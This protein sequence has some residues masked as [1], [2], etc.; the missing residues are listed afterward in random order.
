MALV[1][2]LQRKNFLVSNMSPGTLIKLTKTHP[3]K[4]VMEVASVTVGRVTVVLIS[5]DQLTLVFLC[6]HLSCQVERQAFPVLKASH[7]TIFR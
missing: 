7:G 4:E 6:S 5:P 2:C 3:N 1:Y